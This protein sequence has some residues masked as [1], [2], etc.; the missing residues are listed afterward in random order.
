MFDLIKEE[1]SRYL[2]NSMEYQ[3][4]IGKIKYPGLY[5]VTQINCNQK[6]YTVN[7]FSLPSLYEYK[8]CLDYFDSENGEIII[9]P[10]QFYKKFINGD[11]FNIYYSNNKF[12]AYS[13]EDYFILLNKNNRVFINVSIENIELGLN[14]NFEK[15]FII[16]YG[17]KK[18]IRNT[19]KNINK[20]KIIEIDNP[21][22]NPLNIL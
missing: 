16:N 18:S 7:K 5:L 19:Y 9:N 17:D 20:N 14:Y 21:K 3:K 15:I 8:T 12:H 4:K 2:L 6:N 1:Y 10:E 13:I 22:I 11:F